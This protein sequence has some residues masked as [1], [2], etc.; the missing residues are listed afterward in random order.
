MYLIFIIIYIISFAYIVANAKEAFQ[1]NMPDVYIPAIL[2]A[3]IPVLN[4]LIAI[5]IFLYMEM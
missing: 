3:S 4:T 1:W 5:W 2:I